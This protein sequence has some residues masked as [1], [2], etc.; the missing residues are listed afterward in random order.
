VATQATPRRSTASKVRSF[1]DTYTSDITREEVHRLFK[2][3]TRDA[4]RYFSQ[5]LKPDP[6]AGKP[7]YERA[8]RLNDLFLAFTMKL[9]PARRLIYGVALLASLI[10]LLEL[11]TGFDLR[12]AP[13]GVVS[14]PMLVPTWRD[15][16]VLLLVG[17][18]LLNLLV[19]LEVA[20]RL[21]LKNDL[22]IARDI[23]KQMLPRDAFRAEGI[24]TF[25]LTRPANT[26]GGDFYEI[27]QMPDGRVIVAVGDVAG[28]GSPAALLMALL[29]AIMRTLLDEG[30]E[31]APLVER[32]NL[33]IARHS[34][35]SRFITLFFAVIDPA[36]GNVEYV[37]AGHL[38][39]I[40]RRRDGTFARLAQGGI[41][42]GLSKK[43]KYATSNDHLEPGDLI[44]L[45]SDGITEAESESGVAFDEAGIERVLALR[46]DATAPDLSRDIFA[47]VEM[48]VGDQRLADDLTVVVARRL[49]PLPALSH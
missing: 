29:L 43:S 18:V 30:L 38:P 21:S 35:S 14:I 19:I 1:L 20:D 6:D 46:P 49:P 41:A 16:T 12:W 42:L 48:H 33:Q 31:P 45:Y 36:S 11:F 40:V 27:S 3:D 13:T 9:S 28:K 39:P 23:Q 8:H 15:G 4:Y 22:E 47:A 34:P 24:E 37:N 32:L 17:F 44:V 25:G 26:V 5:G 2:R 10:G 7:W